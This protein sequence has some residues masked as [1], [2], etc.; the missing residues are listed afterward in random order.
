MGPYGCSR[1][2]QRDEASVTSNNRKAHWN[3]LLGIAAVG[4]LHQIQGLTLPFHV[5]TGSQS[6][7]HHGNIQVSCVRERTAHTQVQNPR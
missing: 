1:D 4:G 6:D 3:M 7:L 5:I 2:I